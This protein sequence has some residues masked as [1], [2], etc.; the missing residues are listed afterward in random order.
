MFKV[1]SEMLSKELTVDIASIKLDSNLMGD[2]GADSLDF[3]EVSMM[4]E[5]RFGVKFQDDEMSRIKTVKDIIECLVARE[6]VVK[7][8]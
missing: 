5:E 8:G 2:L 1:I 4:I 6:V 7:K 3:V